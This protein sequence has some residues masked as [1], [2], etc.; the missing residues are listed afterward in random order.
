MRVEQLYD[1]V[2]HY[3]WAPALGE[4]MTNK[5]RA[6]A[7]K[8]LALTA[9]AAM[10]TVGAVGLATAVPAAAAG[11]PGGALRGTGDPSRLNSRP[12]YLRT[13]LIDPR[14]FNFYDHLLTG[15]FGM[16]V[17]LP[18][19]PGGEAMQ[20]WWLLALLPIGYPKEI[21]RAHV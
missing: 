8:V 19:F 4:E 2:A 15:V 14:I 9:S 3:R 17:V 16:N 1:L 11:G 7:S 6:G 20:F 10:V 13:H 12:G 18:R 5:A 21:G